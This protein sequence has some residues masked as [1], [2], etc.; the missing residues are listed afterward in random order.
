MLTRWFLVFCT[1]GTLAVPALAQRPRRGAPARARATTTA[2][3][4]PRSIL[5]FEPGD[6]R[7]LVEWPVLLRSY[8]ALARASARVELKVPGK[9]TLGAPFAA[10]VLS[11]PH[12]RPLL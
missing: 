9:T 7:K 3:P 10:R 1:A 6:D 8:E 12:N 5:G 2:I 4:P 11:S